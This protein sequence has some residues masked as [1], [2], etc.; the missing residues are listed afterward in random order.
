MQKA[1]I[2]PNMLREVGEE[3]Q[4]IVPRFFFDFLDP[5]QIPFAFFADV[6]RGGFRDRADRSQRIARMRLDL[7]PDF[8][9]V[10]GLPN[11]GHLWA[12]IAGDHAAALFIRATVFLTCFGEVRKRNSL[13]WGTAHINACISILCLPDRRLINVW[14]PPM[15]VPPSVVSQACQHLFVM[16]DVD[17]RGLSVQ[18]VRRPV[19]RGSFAHRQ[20][21]FR[22]E[23]RGRPA[24]APASWMQGLL[25]KSSS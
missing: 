17:L 14:L 6:G 11:F 19:F 20:S 2:G 21:I 10:L 23:W 8:K 1:R 12:G 25:R 16:D 24:S 9:P 18:T 22:T 3:R 7:E 5:R 4:H 13:F 15:P